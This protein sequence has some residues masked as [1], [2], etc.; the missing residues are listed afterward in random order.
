M[1]SLAILVSCFACTDPTSTPLFPVN[2][3]WLVV[4]VDEA[5]VKRAIE[6]CGKGHNLLTRAC[7]AIA[8]A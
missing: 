4:Q 7:H 5:A 2:S 1:L 6:G 8:H 3:I